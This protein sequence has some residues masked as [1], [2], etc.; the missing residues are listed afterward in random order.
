MDNNKI[1]ILTL[2]GYQNY[3]NILQ[4]LALQIFLEDL[5][6]VPETI[7]YSPISP[8]V[9]KFKKITMHFKRKDLFETLGYQ[10]KMRFD[11]KIKL[12]ENEI[13]KREE[14]FKLFCNQNITY[15]KIELTDDVLNNKYLIEKLNKEYLSFI[16]GSDQVWGLNGE[17]YPKMFFLP[18]AYKNK[19]NS[20]A[21]SFGFSNIPDSK[22]MKDYK[23]GLNSMNMISVR[24]YEGKN[25]V[26][27]LSDKKVYVHL[28]PTFLVRQDTWKKI[29]N[30]SDLKMNSKFLLTYF[31]G[32]QNETYKRVVN[33][34]SNQLGLRVVNLNDLGSKDLF[35]ISPS[36]YLS[37]FDNAD[38]IIT[39]SFHGTVFSIIFKKKF[40]VFD[41]DD[42][43]I[44]MNSRIKTLLSRMNLVDRFISKTNISKLNDDI[45]S[46]PCFDDSLKV[47][48]KNINES[49]DYFLE[50][51]KN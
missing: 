38:Y 50:A 26:N 34:I 42:S 31:L 32:E 36:Q 10:L 21:A 4:N 15:S 5:H 23:I 37:M 33:Y 3:G 46:A 6:Y 16:V 17:A 30:K 47:I 2:N 28:D 48:E 13:S 39:D 43:M 11:K 9:G 12:F 24:E 22:L 35:S 40:L 51:F 20:F 18:F 14:N 7:W 25:I 45:L 44:N 19:R 41:R 8:D 49:R 29:S 1:G 27:T